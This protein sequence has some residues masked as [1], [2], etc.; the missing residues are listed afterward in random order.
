MIFIKLIFPICEQYIAFWQLFENWFSFFDKQLCYYCLALNLSYA[1]LFAFQ[2]HFVNNLRSKN[3]EANGKALVT[4]CVLNSITTYW[5]Q[6]ECRQEWQLGRQLAEKNPSKADY[7]ILGSQPIWRWPKKYLYINLQPSTD[8]SK[9]QY[10][11]E[12]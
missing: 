8:I 3:L 12:N 6:N 11:E 1:S 5:Q 7:L 9:F 10:F 4:F 2:K